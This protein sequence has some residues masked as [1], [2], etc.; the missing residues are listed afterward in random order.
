MPVRHPHVSAGRL[1]AAVLAYFGAITP[2]GM[3]ALKWLPVERSGRRATRSMSTGQPSR[4]GTVL[5]IEDSQAETVREIFARFVHGAS[6]LTIARELNA[7]GVPEI[8]VSR[9]RKAGMF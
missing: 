3:G 4:I 9:R 1:L 6:C 5:E 2:G 7:R 8:I